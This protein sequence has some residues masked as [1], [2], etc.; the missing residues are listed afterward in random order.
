MRSS[1]RKISGILPNAAIAF[2]DGK[3][4]VRKVR[5]M[6]YKF[7]E[8]L[9]VLGGMIKNS[10]NTTLLANCRSSESMLP[11]ASHPMRVHSPTSLLFDQ[12]RDL[13]SMEKQLASSLPILAE[14][15]THPGLKD[16]VARQSYR[17][18]RRKVQLLVIFR[19]HDLSPGTAQFRVI[20]NLVQGGDLNLSRIDDSATRDLMI[21]AHCTWVAEYG[22]AGYGIASSLARRMGYIQE[23]EALSLLRAEED[24]AAKALKKLELEVSDIAYLHEKR[25]ELRYH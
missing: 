4:L 8:D 24:Q 7:F 20:E 15:V 22:I 6:L 5:E 21:L 16:M 13:Y 11:T 1:P 9:E 12:L 18:Y 23:S 3:R 19:C 25:A 2:L 17:T 14:S 10:M